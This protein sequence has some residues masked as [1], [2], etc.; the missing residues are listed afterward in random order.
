MNHKTAI[1]AAT[2]G[3]LAFTGCSTIRQYHLTPAGDNP[4]P[5]TVYVVDISTALA[6]ALEEDQCPTGQ[7]CTPSGQP[8]PTTT[9]SAVVNEPACE[10]GQ[11][12]GTCNQSGYRPPVT[13]P[14]TTPVTVCGGNVTGV[15]D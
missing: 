4:T 8:V 3:L 6:P 14:N 7:D 13:V 15:C 11:P 5:T 1:L 12:S 10:D 9:I 2:V